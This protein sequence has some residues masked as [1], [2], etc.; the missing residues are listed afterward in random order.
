MS[1]P[2]GHASVFADPKGI[3]TPTI[4]EYTSHVSVAQDEGAVLLCIAQGCPALDYRYLSSPLRSTMCIFDSG[5]F[6]PLLYT[7]LVRYHMTLP[8]AQELLPVPSFLPHSFARQERRR[9][10]KPNDTLNDVND[11]NNMSHHLHAE[12]LLNYCFCAKTVTRRQCS[13]VVLSALS[14]QHERP[15]WCLCFTRT[16]SSALLQ[17]PDNNRTQ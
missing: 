7:T 16:S 13:D 8:H 2:W 1:V 14:E 12:Y 4:V 11:P 3:V 9:C 15:Q 5:G 6:I 17:A 10:V